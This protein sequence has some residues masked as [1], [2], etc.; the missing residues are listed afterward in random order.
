M[1]RICNDTSLH[2]DQLYV[3]DDLGVADLSPGACSNYWEMDHVVNSVS[4]TFV[5]GG[6]SHGRDPLTGG[7]NLPP[8]F[9]SYHV[10]L[11]D[12]AHGQPSLQAIEDHPTTLM[13]ICNDT[14]KVVS[15]LSWNY[16]VIEG[17]LHQGECGRLPPGRRCDRSLARRVLRG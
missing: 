11:D 12:P 2:I 14:G 15:Q 5:S 6:V 16:A 7:K 9:W 1:L 13:R 8:G 10:T 3:M 4:L 17:T